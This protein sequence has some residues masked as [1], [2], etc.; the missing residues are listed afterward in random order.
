MFGFV[1]ERDTVVM[2]VDDNVM[3]VAILNGSDAV[4]FLI[5]DFGVTSRHA[6]IRNNQV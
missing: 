6:C 4:N 5:W 1:M 3:S 2:D